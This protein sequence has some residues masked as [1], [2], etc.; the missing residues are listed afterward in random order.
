MTIELPPP[1]PAL[2]ALRP[3]ESA[4]VEAK[5]VDGRMVVTIEHALL[6]GVT[7]P[8]V[9]WWYAHVPGT[10]AYAGATYPR[11]LVWHPYD[12]I[13]YEVES[14]STGGDGGAEVGPGTHLH[15]VEALGRD[16]AKVLNLHVT[17]EELTDSRAVIARRVLGSSVV[18]LENEFTA[19]RGGTRYRS[20][21]TLGD[22]TALGRLLLNQVARTRALPPEKLTSWIGHHIEEIG[23]LE[24]FLPGLYDEQ[25]NG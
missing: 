8:M 10:M 15:I 22:D 16:P 20:R 17:V 5:P 19:E 11:Y 23:N 6:A 3:A 12:H 7:P 9:A 18:R 2:W 24:N 21:M 14:G 4:N 25:A 1:R 13:S